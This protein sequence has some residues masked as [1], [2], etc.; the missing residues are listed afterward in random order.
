MRFHTGTELIYCS[1]TGVKY[2]FPALVLLG[3]LSLTARTMH[4]CNF[5]WPRAFDPDVPEWMISDVSKLN[6][7][8]NK[9]SELYM[10]VYNAQAHT[11]SDK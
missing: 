5:T 4:Y 6:Y 9:S 7:L 1:R 11:Y 8:Y 10:Y 3:C 2:M